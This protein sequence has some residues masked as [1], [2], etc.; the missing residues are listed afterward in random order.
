MIDLHAER[1]AAFIDSRVPVTLKLG[2]YLVALMTMFLVGL[3]SGTGEKRNYIAQIVLVLILTVVFLLIIDLD[4]AQEGTVWV[5]DRALI[6][7]QRQLIAA[8]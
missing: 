3:Q 6:D 2:L 4:R 5:P 7:L 8:P 1:I